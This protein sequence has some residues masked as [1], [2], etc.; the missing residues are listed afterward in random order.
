MLDLL[1]EACESLDAALELKRMAYEGKLNVDEVVTDLGELTD[2]EL[3]ALGDN[4]RTFPMGCDLIELAVGPCASDY[5]PDI[6]LANA[7]LADRMGLPLH[8]CAY[9]VADVAE[10]YGMRPIEL[11]RRLVRN[12][13]VPVDV[14]H[15][16]AHGPMRFPRDITACE[17]TCYLQGPP[18]RECPRGRI[19]RR[20]V[21]KEKQ[22]GE[23][24]ED[25][26]E[27]ASSICVN[28][29]GEGGQDAEAHAAPLEEM[30]QVAET[31]RRAGAGVGAILHVADGEDEFA[32]G[33]KAAIEEV[34]VDYLAIEG[35]PF[36]RAGDRLSA[37]RRAVVAARIFVPGKV[38]LTNGAYEDELVVGLRAGLNGALSG[39][40]KN[41]HG[42]MV[43]YEPGT[44]RRGKFGIPKVLSIMRR[45][46]GSR[47][48]NTE[49]PAGWTELEGVTR[50]AL[51]L[52]SDLLYPR[53][54]AS[55]P[56]GDV[57][58]VA[59]LRSNAARELSEEVRSVEEV[60]SE[61]NADTVALLGGRFPAWGLALTLDELGVSEVLISDPDAWVE[62]ATVRLLDEELDATVHA[63]AGDDHKAVKEAD[64]AFVTAVM[65]GIAE[66]LAERTGA[67]TVC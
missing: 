30:K 38:V 24:L 5:S 2:R 56:I 9:A 16:G 66:R 44:A 39:F 61:V 14:D 25:W 19:H 20:L 4:L 22:Q 11:F 8:I 17:G 15:I 45:T 67:R 33:L 3:E 63:M 29:T 31:A 42:Y 65:P 55:I 34:K 18:F 48:G 57:H 49:V 36:N 10:N 43:G 40:P 62:R 32:D 6:L 1:R 41:H 52:G 28:V 7:I 51:F 50:A 60:A 27:L 35:G 47:Y 46:L 12:V 13:R 64:A 37:F 23:K 53:D 21:D 54:V 26:A 59:A 58:W